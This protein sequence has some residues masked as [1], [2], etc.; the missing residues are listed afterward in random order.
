ML[1]ASIYDLFFKKKS[2]KIGYNHMKIDNL[3]YLCIKSEGKE[4]KELNTQNLIKHQNYGKK[5]FSSG[6]LLRNCI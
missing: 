1:S 3:L 6:L 2:Q 5:I 4:S